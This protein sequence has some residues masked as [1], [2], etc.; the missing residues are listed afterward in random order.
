MINADDL[1]LTGGFDK[2]KGVNPSYAILAIN[3]AKKLSLEPRL[4]NPSY[5]AGTKVEDAAKNINSIYQETA[6]VKGTQLVF[7]DIGTPKGTNQIDNLY[8]HLS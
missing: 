2:A 7:S 6:P 3:F 4:I 1:G 5:L 8:E